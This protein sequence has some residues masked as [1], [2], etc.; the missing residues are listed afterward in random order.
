M[1]IGGLV[2]FKEICKVLLKT[3]KSKEELIKWLEETLETAVIRR[4]E[5]KD[6]IT[7]LKE[8]ANL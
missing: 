1:S 4:E 6:T 7:W 8:Q 5:I 2:P 3:G